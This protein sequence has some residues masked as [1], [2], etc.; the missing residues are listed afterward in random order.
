MAKDKS[1]YPKGYVT[2]VINSI[3][4]S[5]RIVMRACVKAGC[6]I[7]Y[8]IERFSLSEKHDNLI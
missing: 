8:L 5:R 4:E 1:F 6:G 2:K 7:E 3:P